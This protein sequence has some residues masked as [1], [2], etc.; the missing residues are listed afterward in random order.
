MISRLEGW[1]WRTNRD[2]SGRE[3]AADALLETRVFIAPAPTPLGAHLLEAWATGFELRI[4]R[5]FDDL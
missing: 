5:V 2:S 4:S 1:L 3:W